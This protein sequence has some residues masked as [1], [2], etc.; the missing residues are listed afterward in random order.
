LLM[1]LET[2]VI[3]GIVAGAVYGLVRLVRPQ[4]DRGGKPVCGGQCSQCR[5]MKTRTPGPD[6]HP[7][8]EGDGASPLWGTGQS[9]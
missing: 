8:A 4:T 6:R 9:E 7:A 2:V 5:S 1:N 3:V